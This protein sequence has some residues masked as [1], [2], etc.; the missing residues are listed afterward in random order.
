MT[1]NPHAKENKPLLK[2]FQGKT[3]LI[4]DPAKLIRPVIKKLMTEMGATAI[5]VSVTDKIEVSEKLVRNNAPH[6][7]FCSVDVHGD[8]FNELL[9]LHLHF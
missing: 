2:Y 4:V 5:E 8:S 3:F 9:R 1:F 7:V 6:F